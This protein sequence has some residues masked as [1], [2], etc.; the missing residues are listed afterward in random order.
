MSDIHTS[1]DGASH[2]S[3]KSYITGLI[4][5]IVLTLIAFGVVMVGDFSMP[6]MMVTIVITA[7]IQVLVQL[8]LF[9]HLNFKSEGGWNVI[10]FVFTAGILVLIIGGSL[11]ILH[12]I[13]VNM[14]L[15]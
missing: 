8:V 6:V 10:S 2:G 12:N 4:I 7:I 5:S 14:M 13:H 1:H 3:Y 11:W 15:G 9:M